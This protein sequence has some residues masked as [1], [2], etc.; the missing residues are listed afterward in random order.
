MADHRSRSALAGVQ[1]GSYGDW[2]L[3][4]K[5]QVAAI[6]NRLTPIMMIQCRLGT[7]N[8]LVLITV[9]SSN[10]AR[11]TKLKG[12]VFEQGLFSW[13]SFLRAAR[14]QSGTT[15]VTSI[16]TLARDST[17]AATCTQVIAGKLR[18]IASR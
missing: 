6:E 11:A 1:R 8:R 15:A 17:S 3:K 13:A 18:P 14:G 16:S 7:L 9:A 10:L 5:Q 4:Q 2:K 12:P